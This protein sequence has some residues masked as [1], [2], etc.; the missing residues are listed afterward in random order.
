MRK[1]FHVVWCTLGVDLWILRNVGAVLLKQMSRL[2][3]LRIRMYERRA[4]VF[5]EYKRCYCRSTS[6][7]WA[8]ACA[9][10]GFLRRWNGSRQHGN[11][12]SF[13]RQDVVYRPAF[14]ACQGWRI[15]Q[16]LASILKTCVHYFPRSPA[17]TTLFCVSTHAYTGSFLDTRRWSHADGRSS[18]RHRRGC[19]QTTSTQGISLLKKTKPMQ[20]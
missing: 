6:N 8:T 19:V 12:L 7:A 18:P 13:F 1:L 10:L 15:S 2:P 9:V 11:D 16:T 5:H 20:A 14:L 17:P 4:Q 3:S